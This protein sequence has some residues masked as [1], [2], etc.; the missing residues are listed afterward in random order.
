ME[1]VLIQSRLKSLRD[2]M[3]KAGIDYYM[4]P[5]ADYHNSEYVN[6]YFCVREFFSGF[7]GSNGTL[8]VSKDNAGLWTDGRY[9]IQA[10]K[11]LEG[12]GITLYKMG[13]EGV[14]SIESFLTENM[15]EKESLGFDGRVVSTSIGMSLE[16]KLKEKSIRFIYHVDLADQVWADRPMLPAGEVMVLPEEMA[17]EC[18]ENKLIKV[19]E[20][21][22]KTGAESFFL[23]KL[24]DIMWLYNIRG[25][26]VACNPVALSYT[27][28]TKEERILFIQT[29]SLNEKVRKYL[30]DNG[31]TVK[32]YDNVVPFLQNLK[33]GQK[34]LVDKRSCSYALYKT[35]NE[36]QEI[37]E[38]KAPT[39][40]LKAVKNPVELSN[41]RK[42]YLKDSAAVTRLF[43]GSRKIS[44]RWKCQRFLWRI[45][46]KL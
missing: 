19:W 15:K 30:A 23:S 9:F 2:A 28:I 20:A 11:E 31:I 13:L 25:C 42:V 38:G 12:T 27:Y 33:P 21:V 43:I 35:L 34:V 36:K 40:M 7:T 24:D 44:E 5:T 3:E 17:G 22:E 16:K 39:E 6:R 14:P 4:M 18:C 26:D 1:N 8:V 41:M 29:E 46:W 37:V 10:E 45:I 32:A